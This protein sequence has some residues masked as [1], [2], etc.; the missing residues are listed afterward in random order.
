MSEPSPGFLELFT[1]R[2]T[3]KWVLQ[4]VVLRDQKSS[5]SIGKSYLLRVSSIDLR[6]PTERYFSTRIRCAS[7]SPT[8]NA[9]LANSTECGRFSLHLSGSGSG[10]SPI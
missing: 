2:Q 3:L 9:P 4:T 1:W 5:K 8:Y 6:V 10:P 7:L